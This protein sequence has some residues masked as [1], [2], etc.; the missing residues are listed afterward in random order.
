MDVNAAR[1]GT[2]LLILLAWAHLGL[3]QD[4]NITEPDFVGNFLVVQDG[5][6]LKL[7][8]QRAANH[9]R[10][11]FFKAK[12]SN[13]VKKAQS[14]TRVSGGS[15]L[16]FIVRVESNNIDPSQVVN[17]FQLV[18]DKRKDYR[19][20]ETSSRGAF[21]SD[22]MAIEFLPFDGARYGESSYLLTMTVDLP[23][24]EYAMTLDGSRDVFNMFGVD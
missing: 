14:P 8:K 18:S 6:G 9:A 17:V 4:L 19:Y 5:D 3:A 16:Q 13:I 15:Q 7:E 21:T 22:S 24:G 1:K 10:A 11:G 12:G 2:L 20:I 23:P